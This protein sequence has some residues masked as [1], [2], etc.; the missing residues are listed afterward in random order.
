MTLIRN[1]K[2]FSSRKGMKRIPVTVHFTS[3][4][5][6]E[7]LSLMADGHQ[8]TVD[9]ADIMAIVEREREKGYTD[10]HFIIDE[11]WGDKG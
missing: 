2:G 3:D 9:Y 10:G 6:G 7:T 11:G 1:V 5:M 4:N 8:I